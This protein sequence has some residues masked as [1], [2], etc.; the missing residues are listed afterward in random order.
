MSFLNTFSVFAI[1]FLFAST[2]L[3][4]DLSF[5]STKDTGICG[6][7]SYRNDGAG[8]SEAFPLMSSNSNGPDPSRGLFAFSS[9]DLADAVAQYPD[10]NVTAR[11]QLS[12]IR[13]NGNEDQPPN[14]TLSLYASPDAWLESS[15]T[16]GS[17]GGNYGPSNW[18][19]AARS[20]PSWN[21][22]GQFNSSLCETEWTQGPGAVNVSATTPLASTTVSEYV[23]GQS[24]AFD[25]TDQLDYF[26]DDTNFGVIVVYEELNYIWNPNSNRTRV[27]HVGAREYPLPASRPQI[28]L[29]FDTDDDVSSE[30][31][32][33]GLFS[34]WMLY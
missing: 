22:A 10:I 29:S 16:S 34:N 13:T 8:A 28:I 14:V 19:T 4:V 32:A 21:C 9:T 27:F 30:D 18:G 24:F 17:G 25:I 12:I 7:S 26:L 23:P 1:L 33:S 20:T 11:L 3:A 5:V 15:N 6:A 31:S 2:T